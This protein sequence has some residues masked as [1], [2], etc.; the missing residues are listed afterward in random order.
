[1]CCSFLISAQMV[2]VADLIKAGGNE[3]E[4]IHFEIAGCEFGDH[5]EDVSFNSVL[6]VY[7]LEDRLWYRP[8][9]S[10]ARRTR[11]LQSASGGGK[12]CD[13]WRTVSGC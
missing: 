9:K 4:A 8:G 10:C 7:Q 2:F 3:L 6:S 13:G 5:G 1:M 12:V 11:I